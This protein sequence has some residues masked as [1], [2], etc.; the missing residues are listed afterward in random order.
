MRDALYLIL[1]ISPFHCA[2]KTIIF[3]LVGGLS[4]SPS[5]I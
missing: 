5:R 4:R 3:H 2:V 1:R